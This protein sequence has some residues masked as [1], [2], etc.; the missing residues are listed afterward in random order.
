[1]PTSPAA[2]LSVELLMAEMEV[3]S[4]VKNGEEDVVESEIAQGKEEDGMGPLLDRAS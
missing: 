4:E 3:E 1:M 2:A